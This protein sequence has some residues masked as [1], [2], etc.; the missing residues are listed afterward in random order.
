VGVVAFNDA[1]EVLAFPTA[2]RGRIREAIATLSPG[3]STAIGDALA[4]ALHLGERAVAKTRAPDA[5]RA[6]ASEVGRL[7]SIVL[8]SDGVQDAGLLQP[9]QAAKIARAV[10]VRVYTV[11]L[12]SRS[13]W[14]I[15]TDL[16]GVLIG[17]PDIPTLRAIAIITRGSFTATA[18]ATV[19]RRAY[20]RLGRQLGRTHKQTEISSMFLAV[21]AVLLV[22]AGVL[23]SLWSPRLP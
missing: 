12:G 9:L 13:G 1:P 2:V 8:L 5:H 15:P 7:V 14:Q 17:P 19:L 18:N 21:S 20:T 23:S 4:A 22:A 11:A 3:G 6:T 10:G 16:G